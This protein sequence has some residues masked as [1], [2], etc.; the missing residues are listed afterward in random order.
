MYLQF[1]LQQRQVS[2]EPL[3]YFCCVHF[4]LV[5]STTRT[6]QYQL[7]GGVRAS[8]VITKWTPK[9]SGFFFFFFLNRLRIYVD[10]ESQKMRIKIFMRIDL[11]WMLLLSEDFSPSGVE[12]Q[13]KEVRRF[14][15][16]LHRKLY[17]VLY[18]E[19]CLSFS[20]KESNIFSKEQES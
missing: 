11:V 4:V 2:V 5:L 12:K 3:F 14:R 10:S 9:V 20:Q 6:F 18:I 17:F 7:C 13:V 16:L 1:L 8:H 15:T 19:I